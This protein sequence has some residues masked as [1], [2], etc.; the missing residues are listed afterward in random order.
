MATPKKQA[1]GSW[2][3]QIE[4][5]GVRSSKSASTKRECE[6]WAAIRTAELRNDAKTGLSGNHT[7]LAALR[8]YAT[9]VSPKN[10]G[11]RWE[12][13]RLKA[14]ERQL[15]VSLPIQRITSQTLSEWR[16]DRLRSVNKSTGLPLK[17]ASVLREMKLLGSVFEVAR[18]EWRWISE[19]PLKDVRKPSSPEHRT[20][21]IKFTETRK[22]LK[23]MGYHDGKPQSITQALAVCMLFALSTGMRNGE[24]IGMTWANV[25]DDHVHLPDTKTDKARDVPLSKVGK[26]LLDRMRGFDTVQVF[27]LS[28]QTRDALFRKYRDRAG[29]EG[30]TWHDLRHSAATRLGKAGNLSVIELCKIFGWADPKQAMTYFNPTVQDLAAKL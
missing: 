5:A 11:E 28:S 12:V 1:D 4:I 21:T 24:I 25:K 27:G 22:L 23:T 9:D 10:K 19:N 13:V 30:L 7:L 17:P 26:R 8:K 2:R 18:R 16:D 29:I 20:R 3:I 15:P 6:N 14:L